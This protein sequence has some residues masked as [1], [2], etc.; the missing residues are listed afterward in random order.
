MVVLD[1][2]IAILLVLS[3]VA[4][5]RRGL[6]VQ[7]TTLLA[8]VIGVYAAFTLSDFVSPYIRQILT[9]DKMIVNII[10]FTLTFIGVWI[11]VYVVG[12]FVDQV[13]N[14]IA[15]G[16]INRIL[17]SCFSLVKALLILGVLF[18]I[19][20]GFNSVFLFY[21]EDALAKSFFYQTIDHL[22]SIVFPY[23]D[24]NVVP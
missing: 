13:V 19:F 1:I 20:D 17:G 21:P 4:G 16:T 10:A 15:L 7:L 14:A 11:L 3:I 8:L 18:S 23:I 5:F 2:I 9:V 24:F 12:K 6:V 22:A